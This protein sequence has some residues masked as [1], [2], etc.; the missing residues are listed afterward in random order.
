MGEPSVIRDADSIIRRSLGS[1]IFSTDDEPLE[2]VVVKLLTERKE[3]LA[4]AGNAY[5]GIGVPDCVRTGSEAANEVA[6]AILNVP[7]VAR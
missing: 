6:R 1:S 5:T 2:E 4:L 7:V 3:T